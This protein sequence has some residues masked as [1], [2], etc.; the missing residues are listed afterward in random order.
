MLNFP[1][2]YLKKDRKGTIVP[3][4]QL[5]QTKLNATHIVNV[6]KGDLVLI[7]KGTSDYKIVIPSDKKD[8]RLM[9]LAAS[10]LQHFLKQSSGCELPI[11]LDSEIIFNDDSKII[12][13]G[14]TKFLSDIDF[15]YDRKTYGKYGFLIRNYKQS[16]FIIGGGDRATLHGVYDFLHY[17]INFEPYGLNSIQFDKKEVVTLDVFDILEVPDFTY[18]ISAMKWPDDTTHTRDRLR[19]YSDDLW[20]G[21]NNVSW[22]NTFE[23]ISPDKFKEQHP[24]WFSDDGTQLCFNAHGDEEEYKLFFEEFMKSFIKVLEENPNSDNITITQRDIPTWCDCPVCKADF[25]KY[26]TDSG[27]AIKFCNRVSDALDEYLKENNIDRKVNI[28]FFGY[29]KTTHAPVTRDENGNFK[30][31]DEEVVCRPNVYCFYAPI[32]SDFMRGYN[33]ESNNE[34]IETM[35]KFCSI[36]SHV[37]LWVYATRFPDY[38][39]PYNA[40][41][42]M[43]ESYI[44]YKAHNADYLYDQIQWN[45][46]EQSD[47]LN[48]RSYLQSKL[49]WNVK[50]DFDELVNNFMNFHYKDA[51]ESMKEA[52]HLYNCYFR[53][54][55]DEVGVPGSYTVEEAVNKENY[56]KEFC[57]SMLYYFDK[58]YKDIE[59]LKEEDKELYSTLELRITLETLVYRYLLI[60]LHSDQFDEET[61]LQMKLNFKKDCERLNFNLWV[62]WKDIKLLWEEWKIAEEAQ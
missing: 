22:H 51:S 49:S 1:K 8:N 27:N 26:G 40:I 29:H 17:S 9:T 39:T 21:P 30:P 24:K 56:T 53:Y 11:C 44:V 60:R 20:M 25:E 18:R 43:Q 13:L 42:S 61:L 28:C 2:D 38:F 36:S 12:S 46:N 3:K 33:N 35:E 10:E 37:Y 48:L 47:W 23:Y 45:N 5:L 14:K 6:K 4:D 15:S 50:Y 58:A 54:L 7:N 41:D 57:D 19:Y 16:L 31:I 52:F 32:F 34:F 62:E 59:H 55:L